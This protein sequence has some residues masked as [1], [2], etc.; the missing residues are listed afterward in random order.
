[1]SATSASLR[2]AAA[3]ARAKQYF[4]KHKDDP[5]QQAEGAHDPSSTSTSSS[6]SSSL[7]NPEA[8]LTAGSVMFAIAGN[9]IVFL[10]KLTASWFSGSG[11]MFAEALH[12]LADIVNQ[13]L[14][15]VGLQA[16]TRKPSALHPY[17]HG[18]ARFAYALISAT[19]V[20]F[21]G[22]GASLYHAFGQLFLGSHVV[23]LSA[24]TIAV[25]AGSFV[26]EFATL[27]YAIQVVR[28]L[29]KK[30]RNGRG[31]SFMQYIR[32][33]SD[34]TAIAVVVEDGIAV[35]GL[36]VAATTLWLTHVTGNCIYDTIGTL[37]VGLGMGAVAYFLIRRNM[38][39]LVGKSLE[40]STLSEIVDVIRSRPSVLS[41]HDLKSVSYGSSDARFKAEVQFHGRQIAKQ[42]LHGAPP[43]PSY[44]TAGH[45]SASTSTSTSGAGVAGAGAGAG[46]TPTLSTSA[47]SALNLSVD[48]QGT[49]SS[50][51]VRIPLT[52]GAV[53][54][55]Q[56]LQIIEE[57]RQIHG[58]SP[59]QCEDLV[60]C[61]C[62]VFIM[63]I[64]LARMS[65][66]I[67]TII[68]IEFSSIFF[69]LFFHYFSV[70]FPVSSPLFF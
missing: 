32:K 18:P 47:A 23:E 38:G 26:V 27:L 69:N 11:V 49:S 58:L 5:N 64:L 42:V 22:C 59:Q 12:S 19:G 50:S 21:L 13:C 20:F 70:H 63:L 68:V 67:V 51:H 2:A 24:L 3:A 8:R 34:T 60:C 1:M 4:D 33:G 45:S 39:I 57:Y 48:R 9:S 41:V 36:V 29:A 14:L 46:V 55:H 30:E 6:S 66:F 61:I 28:T 40:A 7:L 53:A 17:G 65:G 10:A 54:G 31:V 52:P 15:M 25:L 43:L 16:S 62:H 37:F 56:L 44:A 35:M